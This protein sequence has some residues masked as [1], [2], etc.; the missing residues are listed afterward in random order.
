VHSRNR[1]R[2][3]GR[4]LY[5]CVDQFDGVKLLPQRG[6]RASK[7]HSLCKAAPLSAKLGIK[8]RKGS[9]SEI[10]ASYLRV[11]CCKV[12]GGVIGIGI[13]ISLARIDHSADSA[14]QQVSLQ[15]DRRNPCLVLL[16]YSP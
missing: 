14:D 12:L 11:L 1:A 6:V 3:H 5:P 4:K 2:G 9:K 7:Y 13:S 8:E 10:I 16:N 15:H